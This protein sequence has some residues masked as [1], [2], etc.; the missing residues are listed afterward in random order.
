LWLVSQAAGR[1]DWEK[2]AL[3]ILLFGTKRRDAAAEAVL[4]AG[5]CHGAAGIA[6]I[7][8]RLFFSSGIKAFKETAEYWMEQVF[9]MAAFEDG[10]AGY[11]QRVSN[12]KGTWVNSAGVLD[13]IAGIGLAL[14]AAISDTE[15][16]W[17][18]CLLLS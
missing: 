2:K 14:I 18:E 9:K 12:Q 1:K 17:D 10:L 7:Y 15:P 16:K 6:H 5:L 8:S 3:E 4:D 11:K 13:G